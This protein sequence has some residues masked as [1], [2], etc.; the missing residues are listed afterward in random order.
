MIKIKKYPYVKQC[1]NNDCAPACLASILRYYGYKT[2]V[3]KM[4]EL[5]RTDIN[6]TNILALVEA[7][8][9]LNF[10]ARAVTMKNSENLFKDFPKPAI[11]HIIYED[12]MR[13]YVVLYEIND[14]GVIVADTGKGIIRY[15][16]EDFIKIWTGKLIILVPTSDFVKYTEVTYMT[17][18][19]KLIY[20]QKKLFFVSFILSIGITL[21]GI[22]GAFYYKILIDDIIPNTF[23][24][25]LRYVSITM[26]L[27]MLLKSF[28]EF[29]RSV[30]LSVLARRIDTKLL[31][32]Y[33]DHV[34]KLPMSFFDSRD[35]GSIV[36]RFNDGVK[37]RDAISSAAIT[38]MMDTVMVVAG[39]W[40]LYKQ[41]NIMFVVC[42]IPIM[43]Y[44]ILV[45]VFKN[46]IDETSRNVMLSNSKVTGDLIESIN[47]MEVV[48]SYSV[49]EKI[50]NKFSIKF[51]EYMD[52]I[53][54]NDIIISLQS[55][56][57]SSIKVVFG[58]CILWLGAYLTLKGKVTIGTFI[59]FNALIAYFIE[60]IERIINLQAQVQ[61]AVVA[62]ERLGQI[63]DLKEECYGNNRELLSLNGD[64]IISEVNFRYSWRK[65]I[66]ENFNM[67]IK[68]KEKVA[69]VG[70]SGSGKTTIAKLLIKL[71]DAD[72]GNITI[73]SH[74]LNEISIKQLRSRIS[75]ISQESYFFSG[76][77]RENLML[78]NEDVNDH[79]MINICKKVCM[80]D[81]ISSLPKGY[82]NIL[83]E[84]AMNLSGGQKQRLAIARAL[85]KHPDILIMD[86]A[87]SNLDSITEKAIATMIHEFT[88]NMTTI[89]IAHRLS[90]I[91]NC[92]TIFVID[93]GRIVEKG[94]HKMLLLNRGYYYSFWKDQ[95]QD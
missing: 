52:A 11:A 53:Y 28:I 77:I 74:N 73:N 46:K 17:R 25:I 95:E 6:G 94:S 13:H 56:L 75:Y 35:A 31:L 34:M 60:P 91:K 42:F 66:L 82:D 69:I 65:L 5:L 40:I 16:I 79:E 88:S 51:K 64:I 61:N 55:M 86:E 87:T 4:R 26:I 92:D 67:D 37:I 41:S 58:I 39:G 44:L 59:S 83:S 21:F 50:F 68:Y 29:L 84:K 72:K 22:A 49:E 48:K 81:Y 27:I 85:L 23:Y 30:L 15:T 78:G 12:G 19:I 20:P 45:K 18:F 8:K 62:A 90:T 54:K 3:A 57:K 9:K 80:H 63:M 24:E 43:I 33:Y 76:T 1:D 71:Y 10:T 14:K 36:S 32:G 47:G 93:N 89:I 38:V 2:S 7:A 70:P